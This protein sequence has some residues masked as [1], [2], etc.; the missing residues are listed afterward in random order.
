MYLKNNKER[1]FLFLVFILAIIRGSSYIFIKNVITSHSPFEIIFLRFFITGILLLIFYNKNFKK[2]NMYDFYFGFLAGLFLF[3]AFAFQTFGIKYTTVAK[4]SFLTSLYIIIIPILNFI[5]FKIKIKKSIIFLFVI[6]IIGLF[7]ISFENLKTLNFSLNFGDFLTVICAFSFA[8]NILLFS[9]IKKYPVNIINITILQMIFTGLLAFFSQ[10]FLLKT[11]VHISFNFS[12][13]YLIIICTM[14]NFTLQN[15]SQKYVQPHI[16]GLILSL[17]AIFGTLFA[18][19]FL[20]EKVG[21]NFI[22][23]TILISISVFFIQFFENKRS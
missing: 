19:F 11:S 18:I 16:I 17:E 15:I 23:G 9:K 13:L 6:I 2:L 20:N 1:I 10:L 5:F 7:F 4:Q 14:L 22:V 3:S 12:L 8:L 21:L